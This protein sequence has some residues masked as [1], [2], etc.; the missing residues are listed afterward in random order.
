MSEPTLVPI[1]PSTQDP[2]PLD[3]SA[4]KRGGQPNNTNALR[5]GFYAR[6]LGIVSPQDFDEHE[7][8]NLLGEVAMLKDFMYFIYRENKDSTDSRTLTQSLRALSLAG[9]SMSR[10]LLTYDRVRLRSGKSSTL[11]ELLDTLDA[12]V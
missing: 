4:R 12:V 9:V 10:L 3:Q 1:D 2:A 11:Y 8:R 6:D 7:L 5:H